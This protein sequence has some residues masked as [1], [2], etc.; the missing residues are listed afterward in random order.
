[1]FCHAL[2]FAGSPRVL[3]EHESNRQSVQHGPRDLAS[4]NAMKQT[5]VMCYCIFYLIPTQFAAKTLN[6]PFS[7]TVFL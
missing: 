1:M 5:C 4:F 7:Y 2:K 3:F 6:C